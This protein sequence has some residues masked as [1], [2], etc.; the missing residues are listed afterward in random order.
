M[1]VDRFSLFQNRLR[2]KRTIPIEPA[3]YRRLPR[4]PRYRSTGNY[5]Y[6]VSHVRPWAS[7]LLRNAFIEQTLSRSTSVKPKNRGICW[8]TPVVCA[9]V[10]DR[11]HHSPFKLKLNRFAIH[12]HS[13]PVLISHSSHVTVFMQL[14]FVEIDPNSSQRQ[15]FPFKSSSQNLDLHN[16]ECDSFRKCRWNGMLW[17][18]YEFEM[19]TKGEEMKQNWRSGGSEHAV[20]TI[21]MAH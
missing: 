18:R 12:R 3:H 7:R 9:G 17:H 4:S 20:D 11:R 14:N 1:S 15:Q 16:G 5:S 21:T 13:T 6:D 19:K 8:P 2:T 10:K